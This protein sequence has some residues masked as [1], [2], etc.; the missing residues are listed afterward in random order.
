VC[1]SLGTRH[2]QRQAEQARLRSLPR[3]KVVFLSNH[4]TVQGNDVIGSIT[5]ACGEVVGR[6]GTARAQTR[7]WRAP[8]PTASTN[9]S[10]LETTNDLIGKRAAELVHTN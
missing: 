5:I 2:Q 3:H 1:R 6:I 7:G 10:A 4:F 8:A 9:A